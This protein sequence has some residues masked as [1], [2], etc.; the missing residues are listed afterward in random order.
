M[1]IVPLDDKLKYFTIEDELAGLKAV[2]DAKERKAKLYAMLGFL[3]A[4]PVLKVDE[5]FAERFGS[6]VMAYLEL[7]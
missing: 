3:G 2:A 1:Q 7:D 5:A 4:N 6:G